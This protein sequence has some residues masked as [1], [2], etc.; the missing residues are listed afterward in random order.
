MKSINRPGIKSLDIPAEEIG[1]TAY[2]GSYP[3]SLPSIY[4][5]IIVMRSSG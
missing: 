2:P 1:S 4:A 5:Y 3:E